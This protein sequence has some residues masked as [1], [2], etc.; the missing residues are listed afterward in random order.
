MYICLKAISSDNLILRNR[1]SVEY[2]YV[3]IF[4]NKWQY[5]PLG[6]NNSL[7]SRHLTAFICQILRKTS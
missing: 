1:L 6:G 3:C 7:L 4:L 5:F 2:T